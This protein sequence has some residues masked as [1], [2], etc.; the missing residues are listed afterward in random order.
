MDELTEA[1][2]LE[3]PE[4]VV[5]R[6]DQSLETKVQGF[7][8]LGAPIGHPDFVAEF[9]AKKSREHEVL[10]DRI[11]AME[12]LQSAWLVLLICAAPRANFWLRMVR[13]EMVAQFAESHDNP[14]LHFA[15]FLSTPFE[16]YA[17][18]L[19]L[20]FS[21]F[22]SKLQFFS[23]FDHFLSRRCEIRTPY[24]ISG[25]LCPA[26]PKI[27]PHNQPLEPHTEHP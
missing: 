18:N 6:G 17:L 5:W 20:C 1:A 13:P 21:L 24:C 3:D 12:D 9:L 8:V 4:A 27:K 14:I 26:K 15:P 23:C 19:I 25:R 22:L 2:R 10:F 11:P 7:K 16:L